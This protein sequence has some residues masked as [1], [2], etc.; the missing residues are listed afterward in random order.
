MARPVF[1]SVDEYIASKPEELQSILQRVRAAIRKAL[2]SA[3]EVISY[4]IPAYKLHGSP[5]VYFAGWK[6]HYSL[7]PATAELVAAFEKELEQYELSKGTIRFPLSSP[8]PIALIG[9]LAKFRADQ[10]TT[11]ANAKAQAAKK[12]LTRSASKSV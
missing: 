3:E 5:V 11:R 8:I 12:T 10:V 7:Y 1:S 2:P 4:S 9:S 6:E